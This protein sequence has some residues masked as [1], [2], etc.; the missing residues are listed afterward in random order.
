MSRI[1]L[2]GAGGHA[3]SMA[4]S[5]ERAGLFQIQGFVDKETDTKLGN[6]E[7]LGTD[8][9][10]S[11]IRQSGVENAAICIGYLGGDDRRQDLYAAAKKAGFNLPTIIDPSAIVANDAQ[12]GEGSFIGKA[13]VVNTK[14]SLGVMTII[15]SGAIIEHDCI[16]K[17]F[18]HVSVNT[19]LCGGCTIGESSFIGAGAVVLQGVKIGSTAI[20]GAGSIVLSN[21]PEDSKIMG[22]YHG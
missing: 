4:D 13:A 10:L 22:V 16:V 15:N 17:S 1:V 18:S 20:V 7:Y 12:I 19:T 8:E 6:Y 5:I 14:A 11:K 9:Y 21:A 2:I 3:R